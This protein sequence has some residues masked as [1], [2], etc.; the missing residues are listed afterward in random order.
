MKYKL[1][2]IT[3]LICTGLL[4]AS[5]QK[6]NSIVPFEAETNSGLNAEDTFKSED[7]GEIW[8][9]EADDFTNYPDPFIT[10]TVIQ[11]K[12]K[13]A[14]VVSLVVVAPDQSIE[15]LVSG[16]QRAGTYKVGY[17]ATGKPAGK[18]IATLKID[19][20]ISREEMTKKAELQGPVPGID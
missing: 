11:Y 2:L 4:L 15:Y 9:I 19:G 17:D 3:T 10:K 5:C 13:K 12:L 7:P 16:R 8:Q 18:Y 14:A 1:L 20:R 6:D